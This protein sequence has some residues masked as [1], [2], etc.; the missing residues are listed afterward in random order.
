[1][2]DYLMSKGINPSQL[3]AK[4]YGENNLTNRCSDGVT[5]T[6]REHLANRRTE[7]RVINQ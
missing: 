1:V 7:F 6:E 3:I 5:C 4:G 2:V